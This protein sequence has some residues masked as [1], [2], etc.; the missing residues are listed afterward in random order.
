[1]AAKR[2]PIVLAAES[3]ALTLDSAA[4]TKR[5]PNF[6]TPGGTGSSLR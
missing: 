3:G 4:R 2:P 5:T 1:M 6:A